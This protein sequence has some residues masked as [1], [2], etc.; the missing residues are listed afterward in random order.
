[1]QIACGIFTLFYLFI[2]YPHQLFCGVLLQQHIKTCFSVIRH[3]VKTY[4]L[5]I[6]SQVLE[7]D[8][9]IFLFRNLR[10]PKYEGLFFAYSFMPGDSDRYRGEKNHHM[11]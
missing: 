8:D 5:G 9:L 4:T 10:I 2:F 1:M 7:L 11:E 3:K 6:V